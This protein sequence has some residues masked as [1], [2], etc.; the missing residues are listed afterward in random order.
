MHCTS[1]ALAVAQA[2]QKDSTTQ[3]EG[4]FGG[5][6]LEIYFLQIPDQLVVQIKRELMFSLTILT[7]LT[8]ATF[9]D[10]EVLFHIS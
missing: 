6:N 4:A 10:L 3:Q 7:G 8:A 9:S 1:V 2:F 5:I